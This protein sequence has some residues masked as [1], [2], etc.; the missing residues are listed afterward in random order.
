VNVQLKTP[1]IVREIVAR[2]MESHTI[3]DTG[4][5]IEGLLEQGYQLKDINIA[6]E[7][8]LTLPE[9]I[10]P[11]ESFR[12]HV[13]EAK[14]Y[15]VFG[16]MEKFKLTLE[17]QGFLYDAIQADLL[18]N[19]EIEDILS[20]VLR[21]SSVSQV[22]TAELKTIIDNTVVDAGRLLL[23]HAISREKQIDRDI[24]RLN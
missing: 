7:L 8:I 9:I 16:Q 5:L 11:S 6:F 12:K 4:T 10:T 1:E 23:I 3:P 18:T 17:A 15:R 19:E 20:A 14:A 2:V 21:I 13:R 22:G 24:T